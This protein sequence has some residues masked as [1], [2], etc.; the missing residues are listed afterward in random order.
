MPPTRCPRVGGYRA[1][2]STLVYDLAILRVLDAAARHLSFTRAADELAV[3]PAAVGQ[4][5][6]ALEDTLGTVLFRRKLKEIGEEEA[7]GFGD[8]KLMAMVGAFIG[9]G[10]LLLVLGQA[11]SDPVT[12][13]IIGAA[14]PVVFKGRVRIGQFLPDDTPKARGE[15]LSWLMF[16]ASG[17]GPYTGQCVH[18]R[19]YAPEK[20]PYAIQ[21]YDFEAWR[22]WRI[23]DARLGQQ[24]WMVGSDYSLVDMAVWGWAR[25][26]PYALGDGLWEHLPNVKRLLDTINDRPAAQRAV[27][28]KDRHTFK[29]EM[30]DEA[31]KAMFPQNERLKA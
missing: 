16:T 19:N 29:A 3:T 18:F 2:G 7:M 30:D 6:R 20:L 25:S 31:R 23:L 8:V 5:I 24:T 11:R 4:Q 14:M 26:V 12:V 9:L 28:L 17:I 13:A 15:L 10:A 27:A 1:I 21:R 22:H